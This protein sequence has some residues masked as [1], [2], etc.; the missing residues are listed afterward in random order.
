MSAIDATMIEEL[1][2]DFAGFQEKDLRDLIERAYQLEELTRH[3][4]WPLLVDLITAMTTTRQRL[5]LSG[6]CKTLEDYAQQ[7]GWVKGAQA[8]LDGPAMVQRKLDAYRE[9]AEENDLLANERE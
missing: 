9:L 4:G 5:I 1:A 7:T 2:A 6:A 3:P 8:A